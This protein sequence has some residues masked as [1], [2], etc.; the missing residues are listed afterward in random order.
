MNSNT[1]I[2]RQPEHI[3][4]TLQE[5]TAV[6]TELSYSNKNNLSIRDVIDW[7]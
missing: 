2:T 1:V 4:V 3:N 7:F 6:H 5:G